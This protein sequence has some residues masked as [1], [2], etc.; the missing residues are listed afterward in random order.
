MTDIEIITATLADRHGV[1]WKARDLEGRTDRPVE[2]G[3]TNAGLMA[4][5]HVLVAL[6]SCT[7]TTAAKIAEKRRVRLDDVRVEAGMEFDDRGDASAIRVTFD[8]DS[9]DDEA[10]VRKVF[11]LAERACTIRKLLALAPSTTI[12]IHQTK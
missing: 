10:A 3:G 9:P 2:L 6:A 11:E 8:V 4:S 12:R 1:H 5:E 7:T